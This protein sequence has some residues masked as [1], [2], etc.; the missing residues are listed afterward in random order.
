MPL[1]RLE[2]DNFKSYEGKQIVGPFADFTCVIGPNGA[3]MS[4]YLFYIMYLCTLIMM[5]LYCLYDILILI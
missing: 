3:G 1:L 5:I 4:L 2:L